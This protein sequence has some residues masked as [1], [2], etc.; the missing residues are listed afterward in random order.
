MK[1]LRK[2]YTRC[3]NEHKH[4][5]HK[6]TQ[7]ITD[8]RALQNKLPIY[9]QTP[10]R[11]NKNQNKQKQ[12]MT[13]KTNRTQNTQHRPCEAMPD[14]S[15]SVV[16]LSAIRSLTSRCKRDISC[17]LRSVVFVWVCLLLVSCLVNNTNTTQHDRT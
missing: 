4:T 11:L 13:N 17:W 9:K 3:T 8:L 12:P 15:S 16:S 10:K 5:A 6:H 14:S 2:S 1:L 7:H